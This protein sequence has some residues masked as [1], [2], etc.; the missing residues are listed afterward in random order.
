MDGAQTWHQRQFLVEPRGCSRVPGGG[1]DAALG[2]GGRE[3][4]PEGTLQGRQGRART[5]RCRGAG[6]VPPLLS[7]H[8]SRCVF[9]L[10]PFGS[11]HTL[12]A[13]RPRTSL[14]SVLLRT[15]LRTV[16]SPGHQR[17]GGDCPAAVA[18]H[19]ASWNVPTTP[20][21]RLGAAGRQTLPVR[22]VVLFVLCRTGAPLTV[23]MS[24]GWKGLRVLTPESPGHA[25]RSCWPRGVQGWGSEDPGGP[26][27][28]T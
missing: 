17:W 23:L 14:E 1:R 28:R 19:M 7:A 3:K 6:A 26:R 22:A 11:C 24:P 20:V 4:G 12:C 9:T 15:R 5:L 25:R 8:T 27:A 2:G 18:P 21:P 10:G 13:A 16:L